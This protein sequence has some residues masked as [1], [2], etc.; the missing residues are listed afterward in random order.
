MDVILMKLERNIKMRFLKPALTDVRNQWKSKLA[1]LAW[2]I[3]PLLGFVFFLYRNTHESAW[4]DENW[5]LGVTSTSFTS[6]WG[7]L[8][9]DYN[10]PLYYYLLWLFRWIFGPSLFV[11]RTFS[12]LTSFGL[13]L[14]GA[15]PFRRACG[16]TAALLFLALAVLS[17]AYVAYAQD[18]RM[19]SM[20]AFAVFGMAVYLYLAVRD[21]NR[22]D[23]VKALLFTIFAMYIHIYALAGAFFVGVYCL[24]YAVLVHRKRIVPCIAVLGISFVAFLPWLFVLIGQIQKAS[25]NYWIPPLDQKIMREA[26]VYPLGMKFFTPDIASVAAALLFIASV[27]GIFVAMRK[28]KPYALAAVCF[29]AFFSTTEFM[30][31]VSWLVR[32]FVWGRYMLPLT[33]LLFAAG[34]FGLAQMRRVVVVHAMAIL[35]ICEIPFLIAVYANRYGGPM[36]EVVEYMKANLGPGDVIV[37]TDEHSMVSFSN[38]F[39]DNTNFFYQRPDSAVYME[40]TVFPNAKIVTD[41][42]EINAGDNRVWVVRLCN[43]ANYAAYV[44]VANYYGLDPIPEYSWGQD[45]GSA[46][47]ISIPNSWWAYFID[48]SP[49]IAP[50]AEP[51]TSLPPSPSPSGD[52]LQDLQRIFSGVSIRSQDGFQYIQGGPKPHDWTVSAAHSLRLIPENQVLIRTTEPYTVFY[53]EGDMITPQKGVAF[54]FEYL[55]PSGT[56]TLGMDAVTPSGGKIPQGPGF[57]SIAIKMENA[58]LS[59]H[60]IRETDPE[61][62]EA[63]RGGLGLHE[64]TWYDFAIGFDNQGKYIIQIWEPDHSDR[65]LTYICNCQAFPTTYYFVGFMEGER[66]LRLDNFTIFNFQEISEDG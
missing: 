26:I 44:D 40:L 28:A 22:A 17:P 64:N 46:K 6:L 37:S 38:Y 10:P 19:Y 49:P 47:F 50:Y 59:A 36:T 60:A 32:P 7:H 61:K 20:A 41:L 39:P 29:L 57:Y 53:Y 34:A 16:N 25:N 2:I 66:S 9:K 35:L 1:N 33:G 14:L 45:Y 42:R 5:T 56:F 51:E 3:L 30:F 4:V 63:L 15:W 18:V 11:A 31:V 55:G 23:W 13:L 58:N 24:L 43:G 54:S 12:A 48:A 8:A 21:G 65:H 52:M 62:A 27:A